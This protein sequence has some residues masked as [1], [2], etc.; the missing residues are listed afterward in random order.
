MDH[1]QPV[2]EKWIDNAKGIAIILVILGHVGGG[3][4]D[5]FSF[6]FVYGIHLV[7]FFL[8]S[9]Y[10]SKIKTID[11]NY[12]NS[13]FR[14][15]M[16]PYFLTCLAVMIS[17]VLNSCFI[18]HDRTIVT[19]THLI[20]QD[21]L[22]SFF[23]SGSV[24]AFGTVEIGTRIGAIWFL[25]AM[26]FASIAFQFMLNKTRSS[27]KLGVISA[28]LFAG[29][30]I[31]AEFIW[32]PF[33]IQSAMMAVIFI[34]I[35]YEVR[36]R[37]ILQKLKWYHFVA[38]Q[39][40]LLAGIWR[41]YCNISF[42][43]GTV[44]D[45]F[46]SVP[47]GIAGCIL[48]YLLAVIDEKGVI[49][50]FFGRNSLLILCTHLFML[51]TRSHCMFSFLETLGLTGHKWG[52]ML[53]I[54]EIGFAVILALIVTLIKN[55]LKNINSELIRKCRE[56]NN[57]RDVTTDIARGIFII[58][59]VMGH[60]GIDMGLWKT[61][62]SCHMIAFV[63]LSGYFYKRPESI[64]KTFLRMIKTFIIPYGVFVLCFFILNIG[65][66]SGAFIKD[67]LIRYALGFSFT[68][69]ILPGIQSVGNVYF[70]LL[71]FVV[72]LI[73]LLIDRFIEWEPGK[74][75]AVILI[76]LFGLALGKTGFW[77]PWSID[78]ACYCLVFYKLGQS[79]REYGI[80]KYIMDEH[81]LYFILTP[82]WV[83]MIYR[84]SMEIAIRNYGEYGLVIAGA[85]CGVLVIMK[86]SSYIADHMPVIRTVLKI[87]G[88]G[89]LY[90]LLFHALLAGRIKTFIS[91]YFSRESIVFLA[92][93]L[94]IQIAGGMIISI[95]VDQLKKHFAHR[96]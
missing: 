85:V 59:M 76:S 55:S 40:V 94:I 37:N 47:V 69:K 92:V 27:L 80:I 17:D 7:M 56:K 66:W 91:S 15:L 68:D 58:L 21:L 88:S 53:I 54:L 34:W 82:V 14:R 67:N 78:V 65:Q 96:I 8:I 39:I 1:I 26:F 71:L 36:Q 70:I 44:G 95:V 63:F 30:V 29:G 23:A 33:S 35:G 42:A 28:A 13:R 41:G 50:E 57:G 83:Y 89:S 4:D 3:L 24:T 51:E 5:I 64:K 16:V 86:L 46:L 18:Y 38:A 6:K 73:Y 87:A 79:L 60:L 81:I 43:N 52:L 19:L 61:I 74:W 84:G 90:I 25:P 11:T 2:R 48:I 62:Y 12:V 32:L 10:T 93:C 49:L 20:D 45:M 72:R 77:L 22:R 9:G 75:V 31:T